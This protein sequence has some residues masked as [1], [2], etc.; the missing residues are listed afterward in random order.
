VRDPVNS[1]PRR[2]R[3]DASRRRAQAEENRRS[4]AAAARALF[5][6]RGYVGTTMAAIASAAGV[7]HETVYASLGPKPAVFRHL[8]ETALSGTD[9]PVA[10]LERDYVRQILGERDAIRI[11]DIYA[12]A[13]RLTHERLGTLIEVLDHAATADD[14]LRRYLTELIDRRAHYSGVIARHLADVGGL[15]PD[16]SL[17]RA[18]DVL[19]ALNSSELFRILA[20]DR[21][22]PP[23]EIEAWLAAT[24]KQ[25]LLAAPST[26]GVVNS[27]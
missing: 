5:L 15:R 4:I 20:R 9:E 14:E 24:W 26:D 3:Y 16:L 23:D 19:F 25:L 11:I 22:W 1:Q 21:H 17:Q 27:A 8:V 10:P 2:R 18:A 13:M 6:E 7:S 12:R